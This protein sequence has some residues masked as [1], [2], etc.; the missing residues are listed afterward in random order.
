MS[1]WRKRGTRQ[2]VSCTKMAT[3][4]FEWRLDCGHTLIRHRGREGQVR[5]VCDVCRRGTPIT[6]VEGERSPEAT[7]HM[8]ET[9]KAEGRCVLCGRAAVPDRTMCDRHLAYYRRRHQLRKRRQ[10]ATVLQSGD[11]A[12]EETWK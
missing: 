9:R 10:D 12:K 8:Y 2:I 3:G 7:K 11:A 6:P 4:S 5:A 1:G